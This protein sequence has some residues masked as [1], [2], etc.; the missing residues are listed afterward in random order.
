VNLRSAC[1]KKGWLVEVDKNQLVGATLTS[2]MKPC[3]VRN[4]S[5]G[6]RAASFGN[7]LPLCAIFGLI[8][9]EHMLGNANFQSFI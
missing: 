2:S 5:R 4:V 7:K 9:L 1:V 8:I 3:V 6:G